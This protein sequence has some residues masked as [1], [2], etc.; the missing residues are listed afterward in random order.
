MQ[1]SEEIKSERQRICAMNKSCEEALEIIQTFQ[2]EFRRNPGNDSVPPRLSRLRTFI[3]QR[4]SMRPNSDLD[5][6]KS[7]LKLPQ[8][9]SSREN[10]S[11]HNPCRSSSSQNITEP[12]RSTREVRQ[13]KRPPPKLTA[14]RFYDVHQ[15]NT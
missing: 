7:S 13:P 3:M 8:Q 1:E 15:K 11:A 14:S 12:A 10:L 6:S 9:T 4:E 5:I 2:N